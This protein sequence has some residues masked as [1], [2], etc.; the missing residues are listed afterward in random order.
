MAMNIGDTVWR[1]SLRMSLYLTLYCTEWTYTKSS[2]L[3]I[4]L[5]IK[6]QTGA[7]C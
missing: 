4:I 1:S 7:D 3:Q 6:S 5:R 2:H